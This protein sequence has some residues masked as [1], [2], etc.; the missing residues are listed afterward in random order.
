MQRIARRRKQNATETKKKK[1]ISTV[2]SLGDA[3]VRVPLGHL[4]QL[5][6]E[7]HT[8]GTHLPQDKMHVLS[9]SITLEVARNPAGQLTEGQLVVQHLLRQSLY[10]RSRHAEYA[11]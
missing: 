6:L 4:A 11:L 8:S 7:G 1:K 9:V 2:G 10:T 3:T 5:L